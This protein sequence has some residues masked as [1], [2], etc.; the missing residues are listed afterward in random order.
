MGSGLSL[1]TNVLSFFDVDGR[2]LNCDV[3][4]CS[5]L[6]TNGWCFH[7]SS[8]G[9]TSGSRIHQNWFHR[10]V[11]QFPELPSSQFANTLTGVT[12]FLSRVVWCWT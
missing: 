11:Q 4:P 6:R 5:V 9:V 8:I 10:P 7:A 1:F 3:E 2:S 12:Y